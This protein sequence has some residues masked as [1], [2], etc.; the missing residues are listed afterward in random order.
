MSFL[1]EK[2]INMNKNIDYENK[3]GYTALMTAVKDNNIEIVKLILDIF[4]DVRLDIQNKNCKS[5]IDLA[6][7]T[8]NKILIKILEEKRKENIEKTKPIN[9]YK[10]NKLGDFVNKKEINSINLQNQSSTSK[11]NQSHHKCKRARYC[12]CNIFISLKLILRHQ[13]C[14]YTNDLKIYM[15]KSIKK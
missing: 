6:K 11:L 14:S 2:N 3:G 12:I 7:E 4:T 15:F 5:I 1:F 9:N 13:I 10:N 8:K